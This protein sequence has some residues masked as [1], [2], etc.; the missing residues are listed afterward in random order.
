MHNS[1][2]VNRRRAIRIANRCWNSQRKLRAGG[3]ALTDWG[4]KSYLQIVRAGK[5]NT[6]IS[7]Y[8]A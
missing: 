7:A 2:N 4:G 5:W 1:G 8:Y 6:D 3:K